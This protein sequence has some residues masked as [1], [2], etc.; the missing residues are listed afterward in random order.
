[1][2]KFESIQQVGQ[3][4]GCIRS[5]EETEERPGMWDSFGC[6][7]RNARNGAAKRRGQFWIPRDRDNRANRADK[8]EGV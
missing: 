8:E 2:P 5:P 1:M 7:R 3:V 4:G 6:V